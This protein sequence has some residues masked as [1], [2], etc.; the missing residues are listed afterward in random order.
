MR[1]PR[2]FTL[3]EL[4]VA[5]LLGTIVMAGVISVF[6]TNQ[7]VYRTN[8]GL[9]DVQANARMAFELM[10]RD[11]RTAGLTGCGNG[12]RLANVIKNNST[13]WYANWSTPLMGY[14]SSQ[15]DLASGTGGTERTA[16]TDSIALLGVDGS[17]YSV[18][19]NA[20]PAGTFALNESSTTLQ[21]GDLV[22]VCDP[23][24]GAIVQMNAVSGTT[25]THDTSGTP[26]N[27]SKDLSYPTVCSS[28]SSYTFSANTQIAKLTAADWY[29]AS[30]GVG[31]TSLYRMSLSNSSGTVTA[32]ANEMVRNVSGM[33]L[34]YHVSGATSFVAADAVASGSW[35]SVDAVQITLT[36]ISTDTTAGADSKPITRTFTSTTTLRNRVS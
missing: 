21:K 24:H 31:G 6:M 3:I 23:D 16:N 8:R 19:T 14:T 12:S 5:M 9:S 26:G 29:V 33:T 36:M 27:C 22:L 1:K 18:K 32:V 17:G 28:A 15:K 25:L 13:T 10:S 34:A 4:M 35:G 2:G 20:E 7:K 30:N 11:I